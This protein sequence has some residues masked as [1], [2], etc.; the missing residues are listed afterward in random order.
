MG[1]PPPP[2]PQAELQAL[3]DLYQET[4]SAHDSLQQDKA[5][6]EE[7]TN[8][9]LAEKRSL[10]EKLSRA[11]DLQGQTTEVPACVTL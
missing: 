1:I 8:R 4:E 7:Q 3:Q 6:L 11:Q 9:L 5:A 2:P 10:T